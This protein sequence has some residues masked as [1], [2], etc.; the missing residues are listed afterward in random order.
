MFTNSEI[1]L[2]LLNYKNRTGFKGEQPGWLSEA[3]L[4]TDIESTDFTET[5]GSLKSQNVSL[6]K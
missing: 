1:L 4:K 2:F 6:Y 5:F 3:V